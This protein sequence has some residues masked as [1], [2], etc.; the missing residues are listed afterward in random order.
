MLAGMH[1]LHAAGRGRG[2]PGRTRAGAAGAERYRRAAG[3]HSPPRRADASATCPTRSR[4]RSSTPP[5]TSSG[6]TSSWRTAWPRELGVRLEFVPL[7]RERCGGPGQRRRVRP[8]HV[9]RGRHRRCARAGCC[10]RRPI[11]TRRWRL[12]RQ[13]GL[14]NEFAT[15]DQ[16]R[17]RPEPHA[18]DSR[19]PVLHSEDPRAP[20]AGRAAD[21]RAN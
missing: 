19:R 1:L 11:S 14:R 12:S 4:T 15:W 16:L 2:A 9:R 17:L 8:R 3:H 20:A 10:S 7:D 6:S 18:R 13:D 5:A 21:R